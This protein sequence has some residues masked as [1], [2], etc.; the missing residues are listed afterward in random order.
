MTG[1]SGDW[2][3]LP[4]DV[5]AVDPGCLQVKKKRCYIVPDLGL[6]CFSRV[7]VGSLWEIC[8]NCSWITIYEWINHK[9]KRHFT[10][11]FNILRAFSLTCLCFEPCLRLKL[12]YCVF[13]WPC[14]EMEH[15]GWKSSSLR[16]LWLE[17]EQW[18]TSETEYQWAAAL[19][20]FLF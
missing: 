20:A 11:T 16:E 13:Q 2:P 4:S 18:Q 3:D 1:G 8:K 12:S 17:N 19:I 15:L 7:P 6:R 10:P 9:P 5:T 14:G